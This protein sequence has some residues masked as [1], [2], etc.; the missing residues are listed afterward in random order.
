MANEGV[1]K[2]NSAELSPHFPQPHQSA[3]SFPNDF[4]ALRDQDREEFGMHLALFG[5]G[6]PG[7]NFLFQWRCWL[8]LAILFLAVSP[9]LLAQTARPDS[10][11]ADPVGPR[12]PSPPEEYFVR[13]NSQDEAELKDALWN[14]VKGL[15]DGDVRKILYFRRFTSDLAGTVVIPLHVYENP[16]P[17]DF[18]LQ[19]EIPQDR[20]PKVSPYTPRIEVPQDVKIGVVIGYHFL[21]KPWGLIFRDA[22]LKQADFPKD[23]IVFVIIENRF[24]PTAEPSHASNRE[25]ANAI[26]GNELTHIVAIHEMLSF[27][28]T[29]VHPS[30][31]GF[32]D[33]DYVGTVLPSATL[34]PTLPLWAIEAYYR[35]IIDPQLQWTVNQA[36]R[37][38]EILMQQITPQQ[39]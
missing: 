38:F 14:K 11:D 1:E 31:V 17:F 18:L 35:G 6:R 27:G 5:R 7:M 8:L 3:I 20:L 21:E 15:P 16:S 39:N 36:I 12:P 34:D 32:R 37:D 30:P 22:F 23:K 19:K 10:S 13:V 28:N 33:Y 9:G 4:N 24:V 26:A 25:I 29:W 2:T